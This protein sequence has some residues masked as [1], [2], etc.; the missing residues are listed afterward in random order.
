MNSFKAILEAGLT[1]TP[2]PTYP[3]AVAA[4]SYG[5]DDFPPV[6]VGDAVRYGDDSGTPLPEN[7]RE[8]MHI[9]TVFDIASLTK[10]F[11]ATTIMTLVED[12]MLDLDRPVAETFTQYA[13]GERATVTLRHLLTHT[14][15]LPAHQRLWAHPTLEARVE[16]LLSTPMDAPPGELFSYSC[17]GYITA[18]WLAERATGATL[19]ELVADRVCRPLGLHDTQFSPP[20]ALLPR[21][22][23]TEYEPYVSR[24]IVRGTVHDENAWS[25]GGTTGNAGLFS[26]AAD[27]VLFGR[28]LGGSGAPVLSNETLDLMLTDHLPE[29]L[30]PGYRQGFGPR[31]GDRSFMGSLADTGAV[32][33]TGFTGTSLVV[34]RERDL[35]VVLLTNRVHPSR[36]W[37][38]MG[39]TRRAIADH[40]AA[41][42]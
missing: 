24:G 16:A 20:E 33:H 9:G 14:S 32:G 23:P 34:D 8:P 11:T 37:S 40:A 35:V 4:I 38:E 12:G 2:R 26:T 13:G 5:P 1:A 41:L 25:L 3:G 27:L 10:L 29:K 22:A 36:E 21:I 6:A 19:P 15:G 39:S 7:Q 42:A 31:I 30:D 28:M 18:G 17:L